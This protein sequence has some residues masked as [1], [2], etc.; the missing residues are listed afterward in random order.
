[1]FTDQDF[2]WGDRGGR[3]CLMLV[4][5]GHMFYACKHAYTVFWNWMET[6]G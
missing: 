2:T 6:N 4:S 1:M 3:G 5:N